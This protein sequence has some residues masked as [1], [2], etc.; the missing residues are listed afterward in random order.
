MSTMSAEITTP[1]N[2]HQ[3][4]ANWSDGHVAR[5]LQSADAGDFCLYLR[6]TLF[7]LDKADVTYCTGSGLGN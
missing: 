5:C 1:G 7:G 2:C 4:A 3:S 6:I